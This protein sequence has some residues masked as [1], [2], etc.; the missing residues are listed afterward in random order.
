MPYMRKSSVVYSDV[1]GA[2]ATSCCHEPPVKPSYPAG[3]IGVEPGPDRRSGASAAIA[4]HAR[5]PTSAIRMTTQATRRHRAITLRQVP[6]SDRS[7][8]RV[9]MVLSFLCSFGL[10]RL[11]IRT[12]RAGIHAEQPVH[13]QEQAPVAAQLQLPA[14]QPGR[15]MES[16]GDHLAEDRCVA[17]MDDQAGTFNS[18]FA[19]HRGI[20]GYLDVPFA[21]TGAIN[22][23]RDRCAQRTADIA[24]IEQAEREH[25]PRD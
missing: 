2:V 25:R 1:F 18:A 9:S 4:H 17:Q 22:A 21:P 7:S 10:Q 20:R 12:S 16:H 6:V 5:S 19:P 13:A 11:L 24:T 23:E 14:K 15:P 8:T 3:R